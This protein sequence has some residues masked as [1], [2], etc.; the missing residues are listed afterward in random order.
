MLHAFVHVLAIVDA[1]STAGF[2][3]LTYSIGLNDTYVL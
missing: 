2:P 1:R 3:V